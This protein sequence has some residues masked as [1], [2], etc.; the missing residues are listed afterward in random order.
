MRRKVL[1]IAF[2][3][4]LVVSLTSA[5]VMANANSQEPSAWA[6]DD[7]DWAI[8]LGLVSQN[9]QSNYTQ[10]IT[11]AEF[12]ALAVALYEFMYG[13]IAGRSTFVDTNDVNVQKVAYLGVV[14]GVGNNRFAP[15]DHLTREQ[16]AV[17]LSRLATAI[18][19]PLPNHVPTFADNSAISSWAIDGVGQ[20]QATGIM[21]GVG[22]NMFSPQGSYTREQ[23]II[24][25]VRLLDIVFEFI[26]D[27]YPEG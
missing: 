17:I 20:M 25:I 26:F 11:R 2:A 13:E 19:L 15:N 10:P 18:G 6:V 7:V 5:F 4:V 21:G 23:S 14:A 3:L 16:A 27:Y 12:A 1:S 24:T 22:N 9:L 8:A